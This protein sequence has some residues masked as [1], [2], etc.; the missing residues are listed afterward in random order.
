MQLEQANIMIWKRKENKQKLRFEML[1]VISLYLG[2][3][4]VSAPA[5]CVYEVNTIFSDPWLKSMDAD[6][7]HALHLMHTEIVAEWMLVW[8]HFENLQ[9]YWATHCGLT[10]IASFERTYDEKCYL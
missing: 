3:R 6:S 9:C 7:M 8:T 10:S 1:A 5:I 4:C 2:W